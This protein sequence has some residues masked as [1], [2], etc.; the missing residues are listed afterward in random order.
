M[1]TQKYI[2]LLVI[3]LVAVSILVASPA[4]AQKNFKISKSAPKIGQILQKPT[5]SGTVSAINGNTI[6]VSGKQDITR[7]DI[8]TSSS[9]ANITFTVDATKAKITKNGAAGKI[10]DIAVGDTVV[11]QG[12]ITGTNVVATT[13]KDGQ[14]VTD[15]N[16]MRPNLV[17]KVSA[18]SG[19]TITVVSQQGFR[20]PTDAII[21]PSS[22]I[23]TVDASGAK[24]FKGDV[25]SA[26]SG[27]TV[28]DTII[29]QGTVTGTNVVATM[30]RDGQIGKDNENQAL[31]QIQGNGQP[32]VA[33][34]VSAINGSNIT[35]VNNS[36]TYTIDTITAK[37]IVGGQT[38]ATIS[39]V[40]VGDNLIVQGTINGNSVIAS[41]VIDKKVS[42][43]NNNAQGNNKK[44]ATGQ[45]L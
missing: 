21:N 36:V 42:A 17:G 22:T 38:T 29:V 10:T 27:I 44:S 25:T 18:I 5:I 3:C 31:L 2:S 24:I 7:K 33:G 32:V 14:N 20:K 8:K 6:T 34:K 45:F 41:T 40:A 11:V 37:F 12:T 1:N 43:I 35:I 15:P 16:R 19:N 30:I 13:I 39:N 23:F 28:G 4:L 9:V 26:V